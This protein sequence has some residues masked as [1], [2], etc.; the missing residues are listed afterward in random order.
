MQ[1]GGWR[2]HEGYYEADAIFRNNPIE[3]FDFVPGE[4][5]AVNKG[6]ICCYRQAA[7]LPGEM[8]AVREA[9]TVASWFNRTF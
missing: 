1:N 6:E 2:A 3:S 7:D 5:T 8:R 9:Q 4:T